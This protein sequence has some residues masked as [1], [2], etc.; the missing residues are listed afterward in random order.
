MCIDNLCGSQT[1]DWR[2]VPSRAQSS[3]YQYLKIDCGSLAGS[4]LPH[5][6]SMHC[7]A[8]CTS[9]RRKELQFSAFGD[10]TSNQSAGD[11]RTESLHRKPVNRKAAN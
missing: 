11:Y 8:R 9:P 2:E 6:F 5:R 4:C 1:G 7:S 3:R 10:L